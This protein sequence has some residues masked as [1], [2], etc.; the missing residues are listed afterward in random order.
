MR[1]RRRQLVF[2]SVVV[3]VSLMYMSHIFTGHL[4][5]Y[6]GDTVVRCVVAPPPN[7]TVSHSTSTPR[8]NTSSSR[9]DTK[10]ILLVSYGRSGSTF[11]SYILALVPGAFFFFEPLRPHVMR[12][13]LGVDVIMSYKA[14]GA[15]E[16]NLSQLSRYEVGALNILH[17]VFNCNI[18]ALPVT[19]FLSSHLA[20]H[21][22]ARTL[23]ACL[24][25]MVTDTYLNLP[26][27]LQCLVDFWWQCKNSSL[28]LVKAIRLPARSV[29]SLM[30]R[31]PDLKVV[32]L[33]RDP[34]ATLLS[35]RALFGHA[36]TPQEFCRMVSD[37]MAHMLLLQ[38]IFPGRAVTVR[39]EDVAEDPLGLTARLYK[40]L[41]LEMSRAVVRG[42][43]KLTSTNEDMG[44][45]STYRQ[46]PKFT[47]NRWRTDVDSDHVTRTDRVCR[48]VYNVLGYKVGHDD[49]VLRNLSIPLRE[50]TYRLA[51]L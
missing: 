29:F 17:N 38:K 1:S 23:A 10:R 43:R 16:L 32:Y 42:L 30:R 7:D 21:G 6:E 33:V 41:G 28:K 46:D 9:S 12:T 34:R 14:I 13:T 40:A 25:P 22:N 45:F 24:T 19:D 36:P 8:P 3:V 47:A 48:A 35:Q 37:D 44:A 11:L 2:G 18:Q 50:A 26:H 27:Y 20:T 39:Y 31:D 15:R 4:V 49:A 51:V 5:T